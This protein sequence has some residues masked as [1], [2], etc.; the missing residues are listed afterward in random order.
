MIVHMNDRSF[1]SVESSSEYDESSARRSSTSARGGA[2]YSAR[3]ASALASIMAASAAFSGYA[4]PSEAQERTTAP[5]EAEARESRELRFRGFT[6]SWGYIE[7]NMLTQIGSDIVR[8]D[9]TVSNDL[10]DVARTIPLARQYYL[11][12][13]RGNSPEPV[14]NEEIDTAVEASSHLR[15]LNGA[16]VQLVME[17]ASRL[18][19]AGRV[20]PLDVRHLIR[21]IVNH[22][23]E[24]YAAPGQGHEV[25]GTV[26]L[27]EGLSPGQ[28]RMIT[29]YL[30]ARQREV[31]PTDA[32]DRAEAIRASGEMTEDG[33]RALYSELSENGALNRDALVA[34]FQSLPQENQQEDL[35]DRLAASLEATIPLVWIRHCEELAH[36]RPVAQEEASAASPAATP[37]GYTIPTTAAT[38]GMSG[39]RIDVS[40]PASSTRHQHHRRH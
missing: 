31:P 17:S 23:P 1:R 12:A 38:I 26:S 37:A 35:F 6:N 11:G 34:V 9:Q 29:A 22:N 32:D 8:A 39:T 36:P 4:S 3:R 13:R 21:Q 30:E 7:P 18:V 19:R 20:Q 27:R 5:Q 40:A 28:F 25:Y 10:L 33:F 14:S 16:Q 24:V 2:P 15:H